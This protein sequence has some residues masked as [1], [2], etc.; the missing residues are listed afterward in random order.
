MHI[1]D[2]FI[3]AGTSVGAAGVALGTMGVAVRRTREVLGERQVPLAALT[4]AFIFAAQMLNFPVASGTS[5]HLLGGVLAAV[6]VGPW[7]GAICVAVVL[8]VQAL[9]FADGGLSALG[10]NVVNMS[11]VGAVGGYL[12][13]R[14]I[15]RLLPERFVGTEVAAGVAAFLSVPMAAAAFTLEFAIG[16]NAEVAWGDVALAMVGAHLLIGIG[17]GVITA[18]AVGAVLASRPDLVHAADG[19]AGPLEIRP[20]EVAR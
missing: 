9:L 17:E 1:P 16:G 20:T 15:R 7:T 5:G 8:A 19:T 10:L 6:L 18:M 3:N 11:L 4:A 14:A 13:F 12:V 2:G